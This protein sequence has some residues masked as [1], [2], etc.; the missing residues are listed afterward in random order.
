MNI[1]FD[2]LEDLYKSGYIVDGESKCK[3]WLEFA[4][5]KGLEEYLK[6]KF[7]AEVWIRNNPRKNEYTLKILSNNKEFDLTNASITDIENFMKSNITDSKED[8][9]IKETFRLLKNEDVSLGEKPYTIYAYGEFFYT[10]N[11][12]LNL[13]CYARGGISEVKANKSNNNNM[14]KLIYVARE[15]SEDNWETDK[16]TPFVFDWNRIGDVR[17]GAFIDM[18]YADKEFDGIYVK[19]YKNG[20]IEFKG[21]SSSD[22]DKIAEVISILEQ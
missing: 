6:D 12:V 16:E 21:L 10:F 9:E 20:K 17:V 5:N 18:S 8:R 19:L 22:W 11:E 3:T 2:L 1:D 15:N 14:N 4:Y 7:S 13:L